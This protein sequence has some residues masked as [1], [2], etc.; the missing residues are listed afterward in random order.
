[1]P[2]CNKE[3]RWYD[4]HLKFL[5]FLDVR[6]LELGESVL[7]IFGMGRG[8]I[9]EI[10]FDPLSCAVLRFLLDSLEP[11]ISNPTRSASL[12]FSAVRGLMTSIV[13]V[14]RKACRA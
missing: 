6:P 5:A 11:R 14:F 10:F 7:G 8:G 13:R 1:V 3:V 9:F 4:C 2:W 12:T